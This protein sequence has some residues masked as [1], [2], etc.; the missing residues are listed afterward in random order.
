MPSVTFPIT[1]ASIPSSAS[2]FII[3][4]ESDDVI[5]RLPQEFNS[6]GLMSNIS[7][8]SIISCLTAIALKS[9]RSPVPD[10]SAISHNA[11]YTPPCD[12]SCKDT[13]PFSIAIQASF[14]IDKSLLLPYAR[15]TTSST[16]F[17]SIFSLLL[18]IIYCTPPMPIHFVIII[19]SPGFAILLPTACGSFTFSV[20]PTAVTATTALVFPAS[21][22]VCPPET[23]SPS[24]AQSAEIF[25]IISFRRIS[26]ISCARLTQHWIYCGLPPLA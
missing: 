21:T 15:F 26:R 13:A 19:S 17:S 8:I 2:A 12:I 22:C 20:N 18:F 24:C 4:S 6:Y 9:T 23:T 10:A 3:R 14:A 25:C 11:A 16:Y 7:H 5:K 1:H